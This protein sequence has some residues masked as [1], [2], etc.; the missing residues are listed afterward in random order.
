M[1]TA[2]KKTGTK[3]KAAHKHRARGV[4]MEKIRETTAQGADGPVTVTVEAV[5]PRKRS[6]KP[7]G[8]SVNNLMER[9]ANAQEGTAK[10]TKKADKPLVTIEGKAADL[11]WLLKAKEQYKDL[12]SKIKAAEAPLLDIIEKERLKVNKARQEYC[13]SVNVQA[14]GDDENGD[15][16]NAG[17]A[18]FFRQNRH[19]AFDYY[20][21]S[22]DDVLQQEYEGKANVRHEAINAIAQALFD[23]G[24]DVSYED[25]EK[26]L[27]DRMESEN[28]ITFNAKALT[29]N[30][31]ILKAL[32]KAGLMKHSTRK[33][34][35]KP[36]ET[37]YKRSNWDHRERVIMLSLQTIG[38]CKQAKATLKK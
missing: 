25:A 7:K 4:K 37:F 23:E 38:L 27:D 13:G 5:R 20:L 1:A 3:K 2:K 28:S 10:T 35:T 17:V 9:L 36:S 26:I 30:P 32:E 18:L 12:E 8:S 16:I 6:L 11:L 21:K 29:D 19:T 22:K 34:K 33:S 15:P 24:E 31:E 14:T